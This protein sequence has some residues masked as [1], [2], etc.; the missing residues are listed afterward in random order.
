VRDISLSFEDSDPLQ[1]ALFRAEFLEQPP[2]VS[3]SG[4]EGVGAATLPGGML[5]SADHRVAFVHIHKTAGM[6]TIEALR[7]AMPDLAHLPELPAAHYPMTD[8]FRVLRE[9]GED[10][11]DTRVVTVVCHP[12]AHAVSI[13]EYWRS[14]KIPRRDRQLPHVA[15][16]RRLS[17]PDF[18]EQV[19]TEDQFAQHLLVDGTVPDNVTILR[20]ESL[21]RDV[22]HFVRD[23]TGDD[24]DIDVYVRNQ[25]EHRPVTD[26]VDEHTLRWI[27]ASYDWTFASGLYRPDVIP[28][29]ERNVTVGEQDDSP[30]V[31]S[32]LRRLLARP[33][34][35]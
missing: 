31:T 6:S 24:H 12:M 9:R 3:D 2:P 28:E 13:Y 18:L 21:S 20:R 14:A 1:L 19:L 11:F 5:Y 33:L 26:Y 10:P 16:T 22:R 32:R 17:F 34:G 35:R 30:S 7:A 4:S 29:E 15:R 25:T 23:V 8:L 27:E